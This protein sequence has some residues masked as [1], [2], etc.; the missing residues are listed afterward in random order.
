MWIV[1]LLNLT[2]G[3][4]FNVCDIHKYVI[5][6]IYLYTLVG[7]RIWSLQQDI[8]EGR[9]GMLNDYIQYLLKL[10]KWKLGLNKVTIFYFITINR[11]LGTLFSI[12]TT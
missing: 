10:L 8:K 2:N 5:A 4:N 6:Y 12:Y 1:N 7:N 9:E 3:D 11:K